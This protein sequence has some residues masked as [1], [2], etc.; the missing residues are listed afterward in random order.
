[1][2]RTNAVE[3]QDGFCTPLNRV[4]MP[5]LW[6]CGA[7]SAVGAGQEKT[8]VR[9]LESPGTLVDSSLRHAHGRAVVDRKSWPL[10]V[11]WM[12]FVLGQSYR[13]CFRIKAE[14]SKKPINRGRFCESPP[15]EGS[16]K[17][18]CKGQITTA[19]VGAQWPPWLL[20]E[21]RVAGRRERRQ[22][23]PDSL[24]GADY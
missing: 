9:A 1:M 11:K 15:R 19:V 5:P 18:T 23:R 22:F 4:S 2:A 7:W 21:V 17:L 3:D 12:T 6:T 20:P 16:M 14:P 24:S 10:P 13:Y 8:K